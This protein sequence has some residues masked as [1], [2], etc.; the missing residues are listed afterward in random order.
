ME[1]L[2]FLATAICFSVLGYGLCYMTLSNNHKYKTK[3]MN[4]E[5][6]SQR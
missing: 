1:A 3:S 2:D 4:P 6:P 5:N